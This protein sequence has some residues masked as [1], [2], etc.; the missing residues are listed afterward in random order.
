MENYFCPVQQMP[1]PFPSWV[2]FSL[3]MFF[4]LSAV[5]PLLWDSTQ[6]AFCPGD[7]KEGGCWT[8]LLRMQWCCRGKHLNISLG[9]SSVH[10]GANLTR[11]V[12]KGNTSRPFQRKTILGAGVGGWTEFFLISSLISR[13]LYASLLSLL[14]KAKNR[15]FPGPQLLKHGK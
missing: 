15:C 1:Q 14:D 7:I 4:L 5:A 9:M 11:Q 8:Q 13:I 10:S 2:S 6:A 3:T 12:C